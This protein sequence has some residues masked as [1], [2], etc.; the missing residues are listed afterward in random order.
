MA[1]HHGVSRPG[2][3][4]NAP[5]M[6]Q[7][8]PGAANHC[9]TTRSG[10]GPGTLGSF[11]TLREFIGICWC[12]VLVMVCVPQQVAGSRHDPGVPGSQATVGD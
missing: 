8:I 6:D 4:G 12:A 10:D 1:N 9:H 7:P 2:P 11:L 5:G 3:A